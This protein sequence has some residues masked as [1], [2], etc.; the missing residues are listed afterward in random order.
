MKSVSV[1][2]NL[3]DSLFLAMRIIVFSLFFVAPVAA[4]TGIAA[5]TGGQV[6]ATGLVLF[7]SLQK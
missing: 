2:N 1:L 5:N 6:T 7:V 3:T 4:F